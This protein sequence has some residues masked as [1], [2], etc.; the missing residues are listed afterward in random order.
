VA[1]GFGLMRVNL[2]DNTELFDLS[3]NNWGWD[4]GFGAMGFL[5]DHVG[6]RGDVRYYRDLESHD[7][8]DFI[9]NDSTHFNYWR[10]TAGVAF[11]W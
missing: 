6:F 1:T 10:G 8:L 5:T 2:S 4:L 9:N 11:R 3:E 7:I